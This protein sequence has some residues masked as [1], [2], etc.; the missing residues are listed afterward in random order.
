MKDEIIIEELPNPIVKKVI[1]A[2]TYSNNEHKTLTMIVNLDPVMEK[3]QIYFEVE[4]HQK[5]IYWR[6]VSL[7]YAIKTYNQI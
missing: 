5:V 1:L 2:G 6:R 7:Q 4:D 3:H